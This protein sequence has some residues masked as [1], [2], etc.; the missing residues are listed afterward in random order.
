MS[1]TAPYSAFTLFE[2]ILVML[3]LTIVVGA[4]APAFRG[5]AIGRT[6]SNT[7][8]AILS[9]CNYARES[10]VAEGRTYRLNLDTVSRSIWLTYDN[11]GTFAAPG[12]DFGDR[13]TLSDDIVLETDVPQ[14]PD[15]RIIDFR[16]SGRTDPA[17]ITLTD[18]FGST[19]IIACTSATE[20]FRILPTTGAP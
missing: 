18:R 14:T 13:I 16:A 20:R 8:R 19:I 11:D 6:N 17:R 10:A 4:V 15:G 3:I 9:R 12:N 7:A 5:F 2:L 1:K